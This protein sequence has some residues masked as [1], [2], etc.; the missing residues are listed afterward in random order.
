MEVSV[1]LRGRR[2]VRSFEERDIEVVESQ[3]LGGA[4]FA[5]FE[6]GPH[7]G[8]DFLGRFLG[9]GFEEGF[10]L[11][12]HP[13]HLELEDALLPFGRCRVVGENNRS[14]GTKDLLP[15]AMDFKLAKVF[16]V[17]AESNARK[18]R[19]LAGSKGSYELDLKAL[20]LKGGK[21]LLRVVPL[22]ED[23]HQALGFLR[24]LVV[25]CGELPYRRG[26][27]RCIV[28][29]ATVDTVE[30]GNS[31]ITKNRQLQPHLPVVVPALLVSPKLREAVLRLRLAEI[32]KVGGII[33]NRVQEEPKFLDEVLPEPLFDGLD[34]GIVQDGFEF[35][36]IQ[37]LIGGESPAFLFAADS[38]F[39]DEIVIGVPECLAV[40][41][42]GAY[43]LK[44]RENGLLVPPAHALFG[45]VIAD[46]VDGSDEDEIRNGNA[47]D[48]PWRHFAYDISESNPFS[49]FKKGHGPSEVL[50]LELDWIIEIPGVE[51][52][53]EDGFGGA[54]VN[55]FID[56]TA[57]AAPLGLAAGVGVDLDAVGPGVIIVALFP[58]S[59]LD[60]FACEFGLRSHTY[61]YS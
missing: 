37:L 44:F 24:H 19:M 34:L 43:L 56:D 3:G 6:E 61:H 51:K 39:A 15:R 55:L 30:D 11:L 26:K 9:D 35:I 33:E 46:P 50:F 27:E 12:H 48:L 4:D 8:L 25:A 23:E 52:L 14:L 7:L 40:E 36:D 53:L 60:N 47:A 57:L 49:H 21:I 10:G 5:G 38:G 16:R 17:T 45:S 58:A 13:L 28:L 31:Q 59:P 54:E 22:V 20:P 29:V 41:F 1:A 2:S 18:I 32:V 42:S